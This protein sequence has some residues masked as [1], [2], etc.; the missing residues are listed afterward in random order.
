MPLLIIEINSQSPFEHFGVE[1]NSLLLAIN[2]IPV[3]TPDDVLAAKKD[4]V[5]SG[6]TFTATIFIDGEIKSFSFNEV[7]FGISFRAALCF[8]STPAISL[9]IA[10]TTVDHDG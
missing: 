8:A 6:S 3:D 10:T 7:N 1:L 5:G 2:N 9:I 4:L